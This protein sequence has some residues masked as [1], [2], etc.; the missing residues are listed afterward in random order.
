M[1]YPPPTFD[2]TT[3]VGSTTT[4]PFHPP[5]A[6]TGSAP[7]GFLIAATVA[8]VVGIGLLIASLARRSAS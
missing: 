2:T 5:L 7:G 4:I 1:N 8:L 3:T 6:D